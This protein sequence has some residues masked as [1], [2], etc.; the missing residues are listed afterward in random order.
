MKVGHYESIGCWKCYIKYILCHSFSGPPSS[1]NSVDGY[2]IPWLNSR[3]QTHHR[4]PIRLYSIWIWNGSLD[5]AIQPILS[6]G[7]VF[8]FEGSSFIYDYL[9]MYFLL[10]RTGRRSENQYKPTW[11][12]TRFSFNYWGRGWAW[13]NP[14]LKH[15]DNDSMP[16]A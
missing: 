16:Q 7:F 3:N 13:D 10:G 4:G 6:V 15:A 2:F 5:I 1:A 9:L 12:Q 8:Y 14:L 11:P